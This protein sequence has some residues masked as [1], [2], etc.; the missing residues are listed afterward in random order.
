MVKRR[1]GAVRKKS[2]R[3]RRGQGREDAGQAVPGDRDGD[4][5]QHQDQRGAG[6]R[7]QVTGQAGQPGEQGG[8]DHRHDADTAA[9]TLG[10]AP[11]TLPAHPRRKRRQRDFDAVAG[12]GPP[13][14]VAHLT[15]G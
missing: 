11:S 4:D 5:H 12:E 10:H 13:V 2:K 6:G 15:P 1:N 3:R 7:E 8:A 9:H 14:G